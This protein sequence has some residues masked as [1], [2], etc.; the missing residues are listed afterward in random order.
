MNTCCSVTRS[1]LTLLPHGL[2]H[3]RL[4]CPSL[5]PGVCSN[6]WPLSWWCYPTISYP[7]ILFS[8]C[9]QSFTASGSFPDMNTKKHKIIWTFPQTYF[10]HKIIFAPLCLYS[11][12]NGGQESSW[13]HANLLCT[14]G[15]INSKYMSCCVSQT[16]SFYVAYEMKIIMMTQNIPLQDLCLSTRSSSRDFH[17]LAAAE[18]L[19][20]E[21]LELRSSLDQL[22]HPSCLPIQWKLLLV[23]TSCLR[24]YYSEWEK[25]GVPKS[26]FCRPCLPVITWGQLWALVL[27]PSLCV[28]QH[29]ALCI[30]QISAGLCCSSTQM[31][32]QDEVLLV[33]KNS[34][35]NVGRPKTCWF[36]PWVGKIPGGGNG[37]LYQYTCLENSMH[38]RARQV[39]V[40]RVA[41]SQTQL[42]RLSK[43]ILIS[44][45][46]LI[47]SLFVIFSSLHFTEMTKL[48]MT[49][50]A[51]KNNYCREIKIS[52]YTVKHTPN[53]RCRI[54]QR[55]C[56]CN[57]HI[58]WEYISPSTASY[59]S[60]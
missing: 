55:L 4:P 35:T 19:G 33:V 51:Q 47:L 39:T 54:L 29:F 45:Q 41:E 43:H 31:C 49:H 59:I 15:K 27:I 13:T 16:S 28:R 40:H 25:P 11:Q 36:D 50:K 52:V 14:V 37:N 23:K 18:G 58:W 44:T 2:Q 38:R 60:D 20:T 5:S 56:F 9:P 7:I 57:M 21:I 46:G 1:C 42:K 6:L 3:A 17:F 24:S 34:P 12:V 53:E 30:P 48:I 10:Y 26:K 32:W 8:S 22:V